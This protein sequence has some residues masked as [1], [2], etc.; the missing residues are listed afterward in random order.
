M[1]KPDAET[2]NH[3]QPALRR[4]LSMPLVVFYGLGNIVGAFLA[5]Y[6]FLGFEDTVNVAEEVQQ[7]RYNL[8][9]AILLAPGISTLPYFA[10]ALVTTMVILMSLGFPLEGLARATSFFILLVFVLVNLSLWRIKHRADDDCRGFSVYRRVP[11]AG[12]AGALVFIVLQL[13]SSHSGHG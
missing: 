10:V 12:A 6:A 1:H 7:P 13:A 9:R 3:R 5:S 2:A 11:A 8:P 4:S